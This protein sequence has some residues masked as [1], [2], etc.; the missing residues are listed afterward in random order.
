MNKRTP[1]SRLR[2]P[3]STTSAPSLSS[4][5]TRRRAV[6]LA[7]LAGLVVVLL[8]MAGGCVTPAAPAPG[9]VGVRA[10][11]AS[12]TPVNGDAAG[13]V[14][15]QGTQTLSGVYVRG[16]IYWKADGGTL[17]IENSVV[18]GGYGSWGVI[19]GE[20]GGRLVIRDATIRYRPGGPRPNPNA[21]GSGAVHSYGWQTVIE[22]SSISGMGDG[23]KIDTDGSSITD[24]WIHSLAVIPGLTHNDC[25]QVSGGTNLSFLRNRME[26]GTAPGNSNSAIFFQ[27][28][29]IGTVYVEQNVMSGGAFTL[30]QQQGNVIA[31]NNEFGSSIYGPWSGTFAQFSGNTVTG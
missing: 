4:S 16:H 5:A 29:G 25:V 18:E 19:S 1:W 15:L 9:S 3:I 13:M 22:R 2:T 12:L 11:E 8:A 21:V 20:G 17:T 14:Y 31:R 7:V 30:Y 24:S 28:R 10:P 27:G 6:P 26:C 23:V